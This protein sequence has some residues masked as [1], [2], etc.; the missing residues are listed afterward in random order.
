[1]DGILVHIRLEPNTGYL[2]SIVLLDGHGQ[3]IVNAK[4]ESELPYILAAGDI[5]S[6]LLPQVVTAVG[7]GAIAAITARQLLQEQG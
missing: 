6:G 2:D 4:M 3:I 1:V 7:D 5:S